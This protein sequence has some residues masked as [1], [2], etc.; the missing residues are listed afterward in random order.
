MSPS[1]YVL[2]M[3][4]LPEV[5][6]MARNLHRWTGGQVVQEI[7]VADPRVVAGGQPCDAVGCTVRRVWRRAK[8]AVVDLA[9][10]GHI[11]FHFRMTGKVVRR[12][13]E[14]RA[15]MWLRAGTEEVSFEDARCLGQM[16][17]VPSE[18]L[19]EFFSTRDIGPEPWPERRDG[20]WWAARLAGL[21]GA[22]KPSL[23]RQ[24]RVAGVGN[25]LA[26]EACFRAG[27]H[28]ARLV[29]TLSGAEWTRVAD[30]VHQTIEH[31]LSAESGDEIVYVNQGGE[32]SFSVYGHQGRPCDA[33]GAVIERIVQAG[34][35]TFFCPG[36]QPS[37]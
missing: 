34:R 10:G 35:A 8:Y 24:E 23:M 33:C 36:C 21:R 19:D 18:G 7:V 5:E 13:P 28:P 32:G 16:W 25:I 15:R 11:I 1:D 12:R 2:G 27:V 26:S 31:T 29:P 9:P 14:Q 22:L 30:A 6:I 3:P 4:E 37:L 17:F 20:P